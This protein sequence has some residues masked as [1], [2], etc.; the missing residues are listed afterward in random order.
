MLA[1]RKA[2]TEAEVQEKSLSLYRNWLPFF[3]PEKH[4]T[5]HSFISIS[6]FREVETSYFISHL[7]SH[8]VQIG[9][10]R[11]DSQTKRVTHHPYNREEL[12]RSTWGILE[13]PETALRLSPEVFDMVLV[14]MLAFDRFGHRLGYG[15]GYYDQFLSEVRPDCL[16]LGLCFDY[17]F[18][19]QD[20][21]AHSFDIALHGVVTESG[22]HKAESPK[23][24]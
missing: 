23:P 15:G 20:L 4:R 19:N 13:P 11:V 21:P 3:D 2:L 18:L 24:I 9:V 7:Q 1:R 5:V 10:P 16:C 8:G 14:P 22:F 12:V 17:G 6:A